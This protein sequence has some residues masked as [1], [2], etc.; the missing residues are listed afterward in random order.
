M[1]PASFIGLG[2][3][4]PGT[5][6]LRGHSWPKNVSASASF[7]VV[8]PG[9][10]KLGSGLLAS[11]DGS[12][13]ADLLAVDWNDDRKFAEDE[14]ADLI[15]ARDATVRVFR[16]KSAPAQIKKDGLLVYLR[17]TQLAFWP[18]VR[19]EGSVVVRGESTKLALIDAN[20]D[21]RLTADNPP[22]QGP[23]L[24]LADYDRDGSLELTNSEASALGDPVAEGV[25]LTTVV[26][27]PD[28]RYY[29]AEVAPSGDTLKL[30]PDPSPTGTVAV[31]VPV[32]GLSI[33]AKGQNPEFVPLVAGKW[34][35]HGGTYTIHDATYRFRD[36]KDIDWLLNLN[37][38]GN[39]GGLTVQNRRQITLS[40]TPPFSGV[41]RAVRESDLTVVYLWVQDSEGHV[42]CP[43][44]RGDGSAP[45]PAEMTIRNE[46]GK[47]LHK[48]KVGI[49]GP[50]YLGTWKS[51]K[52]LRGKFTATVRWELSLF[53]V[54]DRTVGFRL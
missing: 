37:T 17:S 33:L 14:F 8:L 28:G 32:V 2:F 11:S 34:N 49:W 21:G 40:S 4:T 19:Y 29:F 46:I 30:T 9:I 38:E 54:I 10:L 3:V 7:S 44:L 53:G 45:P 52:G 22:M 25:P 1:P 5:K 16:P 26:Q 42:L 36:S 35:L 31:G 51:P 43:V 13:Q 12:G 48:D 27:L 41:I 6:E 23:D 50:N 39:P 18:E 24:L 20:L 47:V 15:T